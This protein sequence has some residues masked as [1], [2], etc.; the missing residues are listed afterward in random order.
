MTHTEVQRAA[1]LQNIRKAWETR[2]NAT[3]CAKGHP[4][5]V[6]NTIFEKGR[7]ARMRRRCRTCYS[8]TCSKNRKSGRVREATIRLVVNALEEGQTLNRIFGRVGNRRVGTKVIDPQ[9]YYHFCKH[10]PK[11]GRR[12]KLLAEKNRL[13]QCADRSRRLIAAPSLMKN[14]GLAAYDVIMRA[15]EGVWEGI[16][17]DVIGDLFVAVGEGRLKLREIAA[18]LPEFIAAHNKRE[19]FS[20]F[21]K[22]GHLSLDKPLYD[23]ETGSQYDRI[24]DDQRLWG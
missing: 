4:F 16:R 14:D 7:G 11:I 8:A 5:T 2:T 20:V 23:D 21:S 22:Y 3:H 15:T 6:E 9:R 10:N 17:Q 24:R 19:K 12:L 13:L 18:R 1:T